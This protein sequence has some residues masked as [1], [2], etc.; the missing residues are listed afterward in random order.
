MA[1][2]AFN[3]TQVNILAKGELQL[4]TLLQIESGED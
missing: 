3:T 1:L 4:A 2:D